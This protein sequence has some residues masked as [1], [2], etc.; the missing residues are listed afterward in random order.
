MPEKDEYRRRPPHGGPG[1]PGRPGEKP[2]DFGKAIG[3][4]AAYCKKYLPYI[5]AALVLA[6]AGSVLHIIGPDKLSQITDLI[7]AGLNG[8]IDVPA[9]QAVCWSLVVL[10]L[11]SWAFSLLQGQIMAY[12]TQAVSRGLRS[13]ISR[14]INRLPLRYFDSTSIGNTLSRV[15]NDVDTI[16]Q[17]LNQSLGGMV[18]AATTFVGVL[19]MMFTTNGLMAVTAIAASL[20][21]FGLMMTIIA[22]SQ[23]YFMRQQRELGVINGHIEQTYAGHNV[24]KV[25]N[26]EK[27]AVAA[28]REMNR[29]LYDSAWKSQFMSGL[30]QPLMG[31][32]GNFGYVS[33]CIVGALLAMKGQITFGVIVAF[34]MYVRL[35]TQP[36]SQLAQAVTSLQSTAAACERVFEFL[37]EQE[38]EDE[39]GKTGQLEKVR[40]DVEFRHVR[41]GYT[42]E[43]TIIHDFSAQ[44]KAGQKIAIVGPTGAGKTTMVN[45]LMRFYETDAGEICIDGVPTGSVTR[46]N[47]RSQFCMVLQDTWLFEGTI[48]ENIVYSKEDVTD[49]QVVRACKAVGLHHY[50]MTLPQGYDAVLGDNASLSQGQKQ[51]ITI[52]RAMIANAPILILDEATSS[53]DTRTEALIQSAMDK[54]MAGRTS[55]VIAH[56]LSTIRNA[57]LILVMKDGDI[58][59][60]GSHQALMAQGG[61]Y[62]EL[63]N[64]QFEQAG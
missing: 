51:L 25:Y 24:V 50:I 44:V 47:L 27:G 1:G 46:E 55:F 34:M 54:L 29:R 58:I 17:T 57:D 39:T 31:F 59:E 14:K 61:F 63:Y 23:K 38:M 37:N 13:D 40:G 28:F 53:V 18:T 45:L 35:F 32:V 64:S 11:C 33:V 56:R 3:Q 7:A 19:L 2:N 36:L 4:L 62:A 10:Y 20:L 43:K 60:S 48:R 26:G 6:T 12:V 41:F 8:A 5:L 22:H 15:T 16:A 9:A 42:P 21:G 52:A 49:E 30:M